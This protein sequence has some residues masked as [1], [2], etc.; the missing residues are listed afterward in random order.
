[1]K[2]SQNGFTAIMYAVDSPST[3]F[4]KA[5]LRRGGD[6][7]ARVH[8]TVSFLILAPSRYLYICIYSIVMA[9]SMIF[10]FYCYVREILHCT[11]QRC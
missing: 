6:P 11:S 2:I 4:L 10:I 7:N 8:A 9:P 1:M 3:S 5:L